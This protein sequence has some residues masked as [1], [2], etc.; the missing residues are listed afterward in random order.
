MKTERSKVKRIPKRGFYDKERQNPVN[1]KAALKWAM[2]NPNVHTSIPGYTNFDML[3]ESFGIMADLPLT[4]KEKMD[5]KEGTNLASLYC[6]G[7]RECIP[8]C[9]KG[10]PV[11]DLMRAYMYTYG[12]KNLEKAHSLLSSLEIDDN[13]CKDC[14]NCTITC[15]AGF[16]ISQKISDVSRLI[17]V[18][19]D[20]IP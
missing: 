12:Y 8:Q 2:Q 10:L 19:E 16:N 5:L 18:P 15:T 1:T 20:F 17:T 7:C 4:E 11:N 6:N 9:K 3:D 14:N 13:P